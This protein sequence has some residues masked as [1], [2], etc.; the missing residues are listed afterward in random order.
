VS[1]TWCDRLDAP[2]TEWAALDYEASPLRL[3]S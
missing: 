3:G 1:H 2:W